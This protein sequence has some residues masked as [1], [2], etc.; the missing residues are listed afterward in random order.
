MDAQTKNPGGEAGVGSRLL[1]GELDRN[2]EFNL[3]AQALAAKLSVPPYMARCI[4]CLL[5]GDVW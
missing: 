2:S 3:Q 1:A 4:L 5:R